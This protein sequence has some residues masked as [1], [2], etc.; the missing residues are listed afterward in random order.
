[1]K[2]YE[3]KLPGGDSSFYVHYQENGKRRRHLLKGIHDRKLAEIAFGEFRARFER[4]VLNLPTDHNLTLGECLADHLTLKCENCVETH[5]VSLRTYGRQIESILDSATPVKTLGE[6]TANAFKRARR[7][8]GDSPATINKKVSFLKAALERAVR[9]GKIP[10]NPLAGVERVSDPR[11]PVWRWL[12]D[13]EIQIFLDVLD[14]GAETTV[15]RRNGRNYRIHMPPPKGLRALVIFLLNTGARRGE[16]WALRCEDVDFG[17][18]Q[19]R[20]VTT[21]RAA[22]GRRAVPRYV[23]MNEA[24]QEMLE[25]LDRQGETVFS[26]D[27]NIKK[28]FRRACEMAGIQ[29]CVRVHD[30]RHTFASHLAISGTP[31]AAIMELLGHTSMEMTLRYA[32]LCPSVKTEA[33]GTLNFGAKKGAAKVIPVG[34][35]AD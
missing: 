32:H 7:A 25:E 35:T 11:P 21:K 4:G 15:K 9:D 29:G 30:L 22:K 26:R 23:P 16:A 2:L 8:Q 31:L 10:Q 28:K 33:V 17:E 13:E 18:E 14:N 1:M 24:L 3:R 19:I 27:W 12:K 6:T 20:L 34:A 5:A